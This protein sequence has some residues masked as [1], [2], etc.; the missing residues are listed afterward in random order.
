MV[1]QTGTSR[2]PHTKDKHARESREGGLGCTVVPLLL[3]FRVP[4]Q[5]SPSHCPKDLKHQIKRSANLARSEDAG[6]SQ[7]VYQSDAKEPWELQTRRPNI[8]PNI[9]EEELR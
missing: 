8:T 5:L 2:E 4:A 3:S 1:S 6:I 7:M 9:A